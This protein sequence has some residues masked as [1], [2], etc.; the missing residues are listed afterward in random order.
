[1]AIDGTEDCSGRLDV[2]NDGCLD[3][4]CYD[5]F[6]SAELDEKFYKRHLEFDNVV[7][8]EANSPRERYEAIARSM[9]DIL[10]QRWLRTDEFYSARDCKRVYYI[11]IEFLIGRLLA[12]NILNLRIDP[13][14]KNLIESKGID[15]LSLL[16]QESD[17]GLGNGGLGRLA[18]CFLDSMAMM[19]IPAMGYGLRYKYGIF[20]QS[21]RD[22]WQC[23]TADHWL[24]RTDPWEVARPLEQ[25]EIKLGCSF[26]IRGGTL[27]A[28]PG[29]PS[30][31]LGIPFDRP[32]VGYGAK[33]INTLR[34]W[35]AAAP[36]AFGFQTF[37]TG[38]FVSAL[39][40]RLTA[41]SLTRVLYPDDSTSTGQGLRFVQEYFLVA[42]SLG[43]LVR[44]FQ[45]NNS[46]W[47]LLPNKVAIHLND[48]HPSLA[49][50]ELMRILLDEAN[51]GW[52]EA[53]N[54]T[55]ETLAYTNHTLLPEALEKWPFRW[56][57]LLLP[58]QLEIILE[59][60]RRLI[61]EA[62]ARFPIDEQRHERI[63]L[64]EEGHDRKIRMANLAIVGSHSVNGVA[65]LHSRLLREKTF[66]D[67]SD[68]FPERFN[69]KNNGVTP[70]RW[71]LLANPGLAKTITEAIGDRW[72]TD[73]GQLE[74]L[75]QLA[76]DSALCASI[77]QAKY[78]AKS[79]LSDW[80]KTTS[81]FN[82]DPDTI[83][84]VH[85][86]RIH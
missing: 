59:I 55:R 2:G 82:I 43:D 69:N 77:R 19:Q 31:L 53:W 22:G 16:E 78:A 76:S 11:S 51:I 40:E 46:D 86:K 83:F 47:R 65:S 50:A 27:A 23:E 41:E 39:A 20:R 7:F 48:T 34:L 25:V 33:T 38:D 6:S 54:L 81:G 64:V 56:F 72:I 73:F 18:A 5:Q 63:S 32:I 8:S 24:R 66:K 29:Q 14:V 17:A 28:I 42:C 84:D 30:I 36:N 21:I 75:K 9:R 80:L 26:E 85:I 49:V 70:R 67:L 12:N 52:D 61:Y 79:R 37:S 4:A 15:W 3:G 71:L 45:K 68:M 10:S 74:R 44:R 58:R 1:M 13:A 62:Q 35:A 60:N 57:E